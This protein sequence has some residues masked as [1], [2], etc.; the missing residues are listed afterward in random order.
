MRSYVMGIG[1]HKGTVL[2]RLKATMESKRNIVFT[3]YYQRI[4]SNNSIYCYICERE[5]KNGDQCVGK[6]CSMYAMA[7]WYHKSCLEATY[8]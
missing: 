7:K 2:S 6:S 3:E 8:H 5:I 1:V 4:M